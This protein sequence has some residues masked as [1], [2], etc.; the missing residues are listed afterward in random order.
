MIV[1]FLMNY[2]RAAGIYAEPETAADFSDVPADAWYK[3]GVDW[4][5]AN[6]ITS[7]YGEGTF[8]PDVTCTRAMMVTF[9]RKTAEL[10]NI[11]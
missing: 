4:A 1:T 2:A 6:G 3:A 7:G 5:A 8:S 11:D 10:Q 9:L